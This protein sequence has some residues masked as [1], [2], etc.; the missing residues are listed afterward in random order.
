MRKMPGSIVSTKSECECYD[1]LFV[2]SHCVHLIS[3]MDRIRKKRAQM[4]AQSK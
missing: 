3:Y 4:A 2:M 1:P